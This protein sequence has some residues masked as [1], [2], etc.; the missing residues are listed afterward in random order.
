MFL[1]IDLKKQI[2]IR[3]LKFNSEGAIMNYKN[4]QTNERKKQP[5]TPEELEQ[6]TDT[7]IILNQVNHS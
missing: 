6:L 4:S 3:V 1:H 7:V 5:L 2:I